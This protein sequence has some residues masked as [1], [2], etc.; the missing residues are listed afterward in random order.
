M[1][2]TPIKANIEPMHPLMTP[3]ADI[4]TDEERNIRP[5]IANDTANPAS[6]TMQQV[7]SMANVSMKPIILPYRHLLSESRA[8]SISRFHCSMRRS[9]ERA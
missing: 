6:K 5:I 3:F 4:P 7:M 8:L 1:S 9:C 2:T